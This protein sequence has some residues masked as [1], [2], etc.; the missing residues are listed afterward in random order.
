MTESLRGPVNATA[1]EPATNAEFTRVLGEVLR[2]PTV[3]PVPAVALR[4]LF[5]EMA[6]DLLLASTR[7]IP[8]CLQASE[9]HFRHPGLRQALRHVLGR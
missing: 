3:F 4:L 9:Y 1:P 5:G 2:R 6:D 8:E 7:V